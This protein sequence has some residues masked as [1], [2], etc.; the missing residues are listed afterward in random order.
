M[1]EDYIEITRTVTLRIGPC[2][3]PTKGSTCVKRLEVCHTGQNADLKYALRF[4]HVGVDN[5][6][7]KHY[8]GLGC[9]CGN[10]VIAL[11]DIEPNELDQIKNEE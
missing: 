3:C 7:T 1:T 9:Y 5:G 6:R 11:F 10:A 2:G 4:F 8:T